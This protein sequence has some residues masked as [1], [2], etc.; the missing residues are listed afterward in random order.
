[1]YSMYIFI[2]IMYVLI[3]C[4]IA[5]TSFLSCVCLCTHVHTNNI[6]Y[7]IYI[8]ISMILSIRRLQ[9]QISTYVNSFKLLF[10]DVITIFF[11]FI[12]SFRRNKI[13]IFN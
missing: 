2:H 3:S 10:T 6:I 9:L 5:S 7:N 11:R 4:S 8:R 1:M 12:Y 13:I